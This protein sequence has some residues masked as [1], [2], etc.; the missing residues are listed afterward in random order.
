MK[1]KLFGTEIYVSFFFAVV[2]TA[3]LAVDRTGMVLPVIFAVFMHETGHLFAMWL[4]KC[5]PKQIRLVPASVQ[6]VQKFV[7]KPKNDII[8]ALSGPLANILLFI[9]FYI[10][11][12]KFQNIFTLYYALINLLIGIFNLIPV[13]GLDGGTILFNLLIKRCSVDRA[14]LTVKIITLLIAVIILFFGVYLAFR[15]KANISLFII[16]IYLLVMNIIKM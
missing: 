10:N 8:I 13:T 15:G 4:L 9:L 12:I 6:I 14:M 3:M 1:L 16:G 5:S 11:Y 7:A 2:I